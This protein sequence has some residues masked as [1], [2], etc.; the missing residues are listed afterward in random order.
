M[1]Q[2]QT[3]TCKSTPNLD[4]KDKFIDKFYFRCYNFHFK[5]LSHLQTNFEILSYN[6]LNRRKLRNLDEILRYIKD[7]L[8]WTFPH[9]VPWIWPHTLSFWLLHNNTHVHRCMIQK[10]EISKMFNQ[11]KTKVNNL[12]QPIY[13]YIYPS[14]EE[15]LNIFNNLGY[16]CFRT[17][18]NGVFKK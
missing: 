11:L 2:E 12:E 7:Q 1:W 8:W 9:L 15:F 14:L 10:G 18:R 17:F 3:L 6:M 5:I 4:H 13:I 16:S